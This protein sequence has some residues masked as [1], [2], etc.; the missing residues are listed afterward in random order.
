LAPEKNV[1]LVIE[2]YRAMRLVASSTRLVIV[3][4]GPMRAT[5]EH[6]H[7]DVRFCGMQTG[8]QLAEH[9]ASADVFLFPS[10]TE[11]FGNV[12]L[13]ALASGLAVIAYDYAA[14]R[15]HI[16]DGA[17]GI[18]IPYG[19]ARAFVDEAAT[20]AREPHALAHIRDHARQDAEPHEG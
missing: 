2:T 18:L 7:P 3:G 1:P 20:L 14:A 10:E 11:T 19:D 5:L 15:L 6:A 8:E 16:K 17:S 4:D 13:E 9:Y 12:T